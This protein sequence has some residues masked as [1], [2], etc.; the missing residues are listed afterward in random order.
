MLAVLALGLAAGLGYQGL[1]VLLLTRQ[2]SDQQALLQQEQG[3][4]A[5]LREAQATAGTL[6]D[7][8]LTHNAPWTWSEQLPAMMSQVA[9]LVRA[10]GV[11]VQSMQP[12]PV[13]QADKLARF[14]LR[15]AVRG[16]LPSLVAFL[17]LARGQTPTLGV[18]E[19]TLHTGTQAAD[20]LQVEVTLSSYV[21]LQGAV[22]EK[23]P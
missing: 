18:D 13:V 22:G 2:L 20:P 8:V 19:L 1:T 23:K 14:P 21:V 7:R 11:Q 15:L 12:A 5:Q 4:T 10:S 16:N 9:E 17:K 3:L 6:R